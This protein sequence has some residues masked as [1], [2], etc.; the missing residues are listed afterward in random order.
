MFYLADVLQLVVDSLYNRPL[1][2]QNLVIEVHQRVLH[3]PLELSYEL[4]VIDKEHLKEVLANVSPVGEELSEESP[5]E[6]PVLQWLPVIG[7]SRRELPPD[8]L[9]PVI[10]DQVEHE[11]VE[12]A[13]RALS[14]GSPSP[15]RPVLLLALDV[16]GG[17]GRG[18]DDGYTR[19]LAQGAGLKENQQMD[20]H[21]RLTLHEAVIGYGM[22]KVLAHVPAD[23]ARV[24]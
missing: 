24:E 21:L 5:G 3:V 12:P 13:H 1:P 20:S 17:N 16:A 23:V 10:D 18:V 15:H 7:V 4:D 11:S 22:G 6:P 14:L 9:A 19:T 8:N 2:Q